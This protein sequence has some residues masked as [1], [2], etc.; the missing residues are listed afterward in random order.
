M[1]HQS[2]DEIDLRYLY[3]R[4]KS[5]I[6]GLNRSIFRI[7][8]FYIRFWIVILLLIIL[9]VGYGMYKD[10]KKS[11]VYLNKLLVIPN[12]ENAN[13]LYEKI[14]AI[15]NKIKSN[16]SIF[17]NQVFGQ[18]FKEVKRIKVDPVVD[19]YGFITNN[20]DNLDVL[21]IFAQNKDLKD[22][23]ENLITS[24]NYKYHIIE[25][26]IESKNPEEIIDNLMSTFNSNPHFRE[27]F[28]MFQ[29]MKKFEI[30]ENEKMITQL[31]TLIAAAASN[32]RNTSNG[33][34]V[35]NSTNLHYLVTTKEEIIQNLYLQKMNL[36][37][38]TEPIKVAN[39]DYNLQVKNIFSIS[40][41]VKYPLILVLLFSLFYL[42]FK[43]FFRMR[44]GFLKSKNEG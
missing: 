23:A 5:G 26:Y 40:N 32:L 30:A 1:A 25:I 20:T 42:L 16:D 7:I 34:V 29:E 24:K 39:V 36:L 13:Y 22:Y 2:S 14:E 21:R 41:K 43:W 38:Y 3:R 6:R 4:T 17:L 18:E 27:Y 9:G 11:E 31:D 10:S 8:N 33:V 44:A 19:I 12:V 35:N 37:D 15:N 28:K